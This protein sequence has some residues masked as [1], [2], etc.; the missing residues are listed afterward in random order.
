MKIFNIFCVHGKILFLGG[1]TKNQYIGGGLSKRG[2]WTVWR[3]KGGGEGGLGKKEGGGEV[4]EGRIDT[5]M[6]TMKIS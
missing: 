2:I 3:F 5:P 4:F 6:H 1:F